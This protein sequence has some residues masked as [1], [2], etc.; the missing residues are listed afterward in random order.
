MHLL[1]NTGLTLAC[2]TETLLQVNEVSY[3]DLENGGWLL[4]LPARR[5][6]AACGGDFVF[7]LRRHEMQADIDCVIDDGSRSETV[8]ERGSCR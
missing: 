4:E 1:L 8:G 7:D 6:A 3:A 2:T 5:Q